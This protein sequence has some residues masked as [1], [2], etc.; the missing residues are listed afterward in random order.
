MGVGSTRPP[1]IGRAAQRACP[2]LPGTIS[3]SKNR[4]EESNEA[5]GQPGH[6]LH[7]VKINSGVATIIAIDWAGLEIFGSGGPK[8]RRAH[9][10]RL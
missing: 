4:V 5:P 10:R 2:A 3:K 8:G 1:G 7:S 9:L 6:L